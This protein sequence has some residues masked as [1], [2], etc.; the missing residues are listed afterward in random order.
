M[1]I[2]LT[3]NI[4]AFLLL[5]AGILFVWSCKPK[6]DPQPTPTPCEELASFKIYETYRYQKMDSDKYY[7]D[8]VAEGDTFLMAQ[9]VSDHRVFFEAKQ[10]GADKYEW[11][12]GNETTPRIGK[13]ISVLFLAD[14][15]SID[16]NIP[17]KLKVTRQDR[18]D[19]NADGV[20]TM[21]KVITVLRPSKSPIFGKYVAYDENNQPK[22]IEIYRPV[23]PTEF[24]YDPNVVNIKI[25]NLIGSGSC[26]AF[27]NY[28][29][30]YATAFSFTF[31]WMDDWYS[32]INCLIKRSWGYLDPLNRNKLVL[33]Y[34]IR[35]SASG[36]T[37]IPM[38]KNIVAYRIP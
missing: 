18:K 15:I 19:C 22:I 21:I 8:G 12:I 10:E 3:K 35:G 37:F 11:W 25:R 14:N 36:S 34:Y 20:Y 4:Y 32:G 24:G 9:G 33:T 16:I 23:D 28:T 26:N 38:V 5:L 17:I 27:V 31:S 7:D 6:K 30:E 2:L 13:K 1:N 29:T